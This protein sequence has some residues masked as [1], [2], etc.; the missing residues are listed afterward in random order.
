VQDI[1]DTGVG[2]DCYLKVTAQRG[3]GGCD[4]DATSRQQQQQ[5]QL[6]LPNNVNGEAMLEEL[7]EPDN[8]LI[9]CL[10]RSA[11]STECYQ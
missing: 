1:E 9:I 5:Q 6:T 11:N 4:L 2:E 10:D 3:E 7:G 8:F